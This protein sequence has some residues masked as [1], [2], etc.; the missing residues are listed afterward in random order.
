M[1]K[2]LIVDDEKWIRRGLKV[3]LEELGYQFEEILEAKNGMDALEI[4]EKELPKLVITDIRMPKMSGIDV[5]REGIKISKDIKFVII[6]GYA[7]FDYAEKAINMGAKGYLLKPINDKNLKETMDKLLGEIEREKEYHQ[8]M[9]KANKLEDS[10][11]DNGKEKDINELILDDKITQVAIKDIM[12]EEYSYCSMALINIDASSYFQSNFK[13]EDLELLKFSINN[14]MNEITPSDFHY[15]ICNNHTNRNQMIMIMANNQGMNFQK[16]VEEK[17]YDL[18]NSINKYLKISVT[19]GVSKVH[20]DI[21]RQ[22]YSEAKE[23]YEFNF[24]D[25]RGKIYQYESVKY[26]TENA[27]QIPR[28]KIKLLKMYM[29]KGDAK[30][31]R[32]ILESLINTDTIKEQSIKYISFIWFEIVSILI[33]SLDAIEKKNQR[34]LSTSLL[35]PEIFERYENVDE[36]VN[37]LYTTMIDILGIKE[38]QDQ[39]CKEIVYK[40]KAFI[41]QNYEQDIAIKELAYEYAINPKY[42]STLFKKEIGMSAVQYIT[43]KRLVQAC[44]LL[45]HTGQSIT[46]ISNSVGYQDPLYFF[47]VFKKKYDMTPLEYRNKFQD[48]K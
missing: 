10:F 41:D 40:V 9:V 23:A 25:G 36:V 38:D 47:R 32:I 14:I 4:I 18:L 33:N 7:E 44:E 29:S 8:V 19:I 46:D 34:L 21:N 48:K 3:K 13:Y 22:Q 39:D 43:N 16:I 1:Q 11:V 17:L 31:I 45:V 42:F 30:N 15:F 37:Y 26:M 12:D 5:I 28:D 6:S 20:Y 24:I 2:L 35:Q 27:I